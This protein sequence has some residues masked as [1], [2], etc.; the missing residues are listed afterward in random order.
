MNI[1]IGL[2]FEQEFNLK[3]YQQQVENLDLPTAQ[4]LLLEVLRQLMVKENL[5]KQMIKNGI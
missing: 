3:V 2:S 5:L 1:P 4:N